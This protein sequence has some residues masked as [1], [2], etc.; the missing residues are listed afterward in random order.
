[1]KVE[2]ETLKEWIEN[3]IYKEKYY[4]PFSKGKNIPISELYDLIDQLCRYESVMECIREEK[5]NADC[6]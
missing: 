1:M 3:W 2:V 6:H 5:E 4:H